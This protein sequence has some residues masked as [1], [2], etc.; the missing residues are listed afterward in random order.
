[1]E[2]FA[3]R[4]VINKPFMFITKGVWKRGESLFIYWSDLEIITN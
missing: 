4:K 1:M 3:D 2:K